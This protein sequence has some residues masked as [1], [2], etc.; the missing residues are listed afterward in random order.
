MH[1][2][3]NYS[4]TIL[5]VLQGGADKE[6]KIDFSV[7]WGYQQNWCENS[8]LLLDLSKIIPI[9]KVED[10][11]KITCPSSGC[12]LLRGWH[13]WL[14]SNLCWALLRCPWSGCSPSGHEVMSA[15]FIF[16]GCFSYLAYLS[17]EE[18]M[19]EESFLRGEVS[20]STKSCEFK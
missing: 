12:Q 13:S 4:L 14:L 1:I 16:S 10:S 9:W 7:S 17:T 3:S 8:E 20:Q 11:S 15:Q 2:L 18:D 6:L 5:G 19:N